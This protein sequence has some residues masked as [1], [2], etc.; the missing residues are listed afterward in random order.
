[1][2]AVDQSEPKRKS[3]VA[4]I[5]RR[6]NLRFPFTA[7]VEAV[8]TKS[9]TK[10][11]ARTSDLSLGGCYIDTLSPFPVGSEVQIRISRNKETFEAQAKVVY[12][13]IG[14]GMGVA[15]LS[16][17]PKQVRLFQRWLLEISGKGGPPAEADIKES[18]E[19]APAGNTQALMKSGVLSDLIM[20]LMKKKVL[21]EAE[22]KE[23]LRKLFT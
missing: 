6:R 21:T 5:E 19:N 13:M 7:T 2:S 1:M 4:A 12:S 10:I 16:A 20:T 8:E 23:M 3:S 17:Q 14:M 11:V 9:G 22:G 18:D 15:F